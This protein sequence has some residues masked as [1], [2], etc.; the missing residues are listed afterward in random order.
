MDD[1]CFYGFPIFGEAGPKVGQDAGGEE[2]TANTR[3]FE[4][5]PAA[6]ARVTRFLERYLP[7]AGGPGLA[8]HTCLNTHTPA[9]DVVLR[10]QPERPAVSVAVG[11]GHAFTFASVI[12]RI[13]AELAVESRSA[14]DLAPFAVDRAILQLA[15]PPRTYMV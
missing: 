9:R 6:L 1:P 14:H 15:D 4:P 7:G 10:T 5:D 13:L 8:T 12:G 2:T 3:T 11:G